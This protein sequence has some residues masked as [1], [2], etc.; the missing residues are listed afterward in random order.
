VSTAA[1]R[2]SEPDADPLLPRS[3]GI[4]VAQW[5]FGAAPHVSGTC[6]TDTNESQAALRLRLAIVEA[7]IDRVSS[8]RLR[9][10]ELIKDL[11]DLRGRLLAALDELSARLRRVDQSRVR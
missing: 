6:T 7:S 9:Y 1:R 10:A 3:P 5:R 2:R 11:E 8:D 4:G